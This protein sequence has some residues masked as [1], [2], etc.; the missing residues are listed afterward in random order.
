[1]ETCVRIR[2]CCADV[3]AIFG[4]PDCGRWCGDAPVRHAP[5][6]SPSRPGRTP[7]PRNKRGALSFTGRRRHV[8]RHAC[9]LRHL[10]RVA[11]E[12]GRVRHILEATV[13][14]C[15]RRAPMFRHEM[16]ERMMLLGI[17]SCATIG[18]CAISPARLAPGRR[19]PPSRSPCLA[20]LPW[21]T[22]SP[23]S[24]LQH[25]TSM[26]LRRCSTSLRRIVRSMLLCNSSSV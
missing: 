25:P 1:M 19:C 2:T 17:S 22:P 20:R 18:T 12:A 10:F 7:P 9:Q 26:I 8:G 13:R 4:G 24:N 5:H 23:L 15:Q 14:L 3:A 6:W 16:M 11:H 21:A